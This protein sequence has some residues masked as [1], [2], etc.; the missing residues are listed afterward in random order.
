MR[1]SGNSL[2]ADSRRSTSAA[3]V[4]TVCGPGSAPSAVESPWQR[5]STSK[6][7]QCGNP[8]RASKQ[9]KGLVLARWQGQ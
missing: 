8:C 6:T 4:V 3:A 5:R 9:G 2:S 1:T 7:C